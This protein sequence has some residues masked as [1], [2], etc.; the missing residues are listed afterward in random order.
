MRDRPKRWVW[1]GGV[2]VTGLVA[3]GAAAQ[4]SF[5]GA[6]QGEAPSGD[7]LVS[8]S[9]ASEHSPFDPRAGTTLAL[10][11][12]VAED[13][14]I[15][16]RNSGDSGMP[17]VWELELPQGVTLGEPRWPTPSRYETAGVVLDNVL[18][19]QVVI[20]L[21]LEIDQAMVAS[22]VEAG[23]GELTIRATSDWLVCKDVCLPGTGEAEIVLPFAAMDGAS[24]NKDLFKAAREALPI[25]AADI[26]EGELGYGVRAEFVAGEL[27]VHA[28]GAQRLEWFGWEQERSPAI[29]NPI[30]S[31]AVD[32]ERMRVAYAPESAEAPVIGGVLRIYADAD[33]DDGVAVRLSVDGPAARVQR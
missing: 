10:V 33:D 27:R 22:M 1:P 18:E 12:D 6:G 29:E 14:H 23:T 31:G 20:L 8:L 25:D 30:I 13:W 2:A 3:A 32:G 17:P 5:P 21:P 19:G 28:P 15:Y 4:F 16:W 24:A 7:D 11:Y 26:P 9:L